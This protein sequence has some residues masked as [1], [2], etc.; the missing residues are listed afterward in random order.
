MKRFIVAAVAVGL[1]TVG[2]AGVAAAQT[3]GSGS[4]S[5]TS[6]PAGP[7]G[8][9]TGAQRRARGVLVIAAKTL[10]VKPREL[11][12]GLCG[13]QTI[14]QIASQHGKST[15]DITAAVVK[16][17]DARIDKAVKAGK[18]DATQAARRKSAVES[19]VTARIGSYKPSAALCQKLQ[20]SANAGTPSA[21]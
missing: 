12:T 10:G 6:Q 18:L 19:Q 17:A 9:A 11:V 1:L 8:K 21:T 2:T 20:G 14:D 4:S 3:T 15:K 16:A 7:Q 13:G 5:S